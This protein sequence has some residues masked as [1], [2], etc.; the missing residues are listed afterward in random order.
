MRRWALG[1]LAAVV[2]VLGICALYA[3]YMVRHGF[4]PRTPP[5]GMETALATGNRSGLRELSARG[6]ALKKECTC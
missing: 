4:S 5:S 2:L 3:T 1:I 6:P